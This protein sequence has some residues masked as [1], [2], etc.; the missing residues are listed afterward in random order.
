MAR[1]NEDT[2]LL[3]YREPIKDTLVPYDRYLRKA[4][5][6]LY[7][8][9]RG[10]QK[11]TGFQVQFLALVKA[12]RLAGCRVEVNNYRLARRH[13]VHPVG[14]AGYPDI[15]DGWEL[16]NPAV[17]GPG[18]LDHPKLR[19]DLMKDPR[20]RY[21]IVTCDWMR[22]LFAPYYGDTLV[23]WYGGIDLEK[24]PDQRQKP[25][26]LDVLVY[27]KVRW[28]MKVR[29][30]EL[31]EPILRWLDQKGSSWHRLRYRGYQHSSYRKLLGQARAMLFLCEH[32]TQGFAY[33]EAMASNVPVLAWDNGLWCDPH[34]LRFGHAPVPA[35]SVPYFSAEC[36]ERFRGW[37]DFPE[38]AELFWSRLA[39]YEPRRYVARE[40]SFEGSAQLY[41]RY[42]RSL[43]PEARRAPA[44]RNVARH[45]PAARASGSGNAVA[46]PEN[47]VRVSL[48]GVPI[49]SLTFAE[50][51]DEIEKLV[52]SG[53]GGYVV[54][55]NVDHVVLLERD[56]RL[57]RAYA[58]ASLVLVDGKPL[59]W[60]SRL[61]GTP[62]P[63][64][65][66]G[67][68]LVLPLVERAA[69]R[70]W[71]VFLSGGASGVAEAA[72]ERLRARL[73]VEI[74]GTDAPRIRLSHEGPAEGGEDTVERIRAS[75]AQIAF[76]AYGSPKQELWLSQHAEALRPTVAIGIGA[77]LDFVAGTARR[78]PRWASEAGLEWAFRLAH[79]PG[80]LWRRYLVEDPK[81][82]AILA[83]AL[84][85][86][87][88]ERG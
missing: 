82:F 51:L 19:P 45:R 71:R 59:V 36:G 73:G 81:F 18:M 40:L 53:R 70:G 3:F 72:A 52:E 46:V 83:R 11:V 35:T 41:L 75:G 77:G 57:R 1:L 43:M 17:I 10:D 20:F 5:R 69:S 74:A 42:Y 76:F 28:D 21:Y 64:K 12:L 22:D 14:L 37:D 30:H 84:R 39:S 16:P 44:P 25:K 87:W 2:V 9:L 24:W 23:P 29:E 13:P 61:L 6:P 63:E 47:R 54:T 34:R 49:D 88:A 32:E 31:V 85:A 8:R 27:D 60:A 33:Q 86:R 38:K 79:E 50:A 68:D 65:I 15:L 67:S 66:S 4:V 48:A 78:A 62:L 58:Q 80:R 56:E 55:P 26:S 7:K